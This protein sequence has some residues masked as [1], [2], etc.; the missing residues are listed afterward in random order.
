MKEILKENKKTFIVAGIS[1]IVLFL[2]VFIVSILNNNTNNYALKC[3][4]DSSTDEMTITQTFIVHDYADYRQLELRFYY[5]LEEVVKEYY[6]E[7]SRL[8]YKSLEAK[9]KSVYGESSK[10]FK[11]SLEEKKDGVEVIV[12]LTI[13]SDNSDKLSELVEYDFWNTSIA[14][15]RNT[16]ESGGLTCE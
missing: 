10:D 6:D 11:I 2:L 5:S 12:I 16:L 9:I 8:V 1:F 3:V 7:F 13:N 14:E 4:Y 15:L